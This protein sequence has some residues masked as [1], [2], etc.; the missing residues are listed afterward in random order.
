MT[1]GNLLICPRAIAS[2]PRSNSVPGGG[3]HILSALGGQRNA[4]A[5][6]ETRFGRAQCVA[7][8]PSARSCAARYF[9]AINCALD[10]R[11]RCSRAFS[12]KSAVRTVSRPSE[13]RRGKPLSN[14]YIFFSKIRDFVFNFPT[15]NFIM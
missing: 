2:R 4:R 8:P 13:V 15:P 14:G 6:G 11:I 12:S 5:F 3:D 10:R 1:I 9:N 7:Y